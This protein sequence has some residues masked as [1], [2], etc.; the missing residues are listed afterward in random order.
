MKVLE[1]VI[2]RRLR[3]IV[4]IDSLQFGRCGRE[5]H[6]RCHFHRPSPSATGEIHGK[7]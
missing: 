3:K 2:E 4:K 5:E 1:S 7:E 6:N